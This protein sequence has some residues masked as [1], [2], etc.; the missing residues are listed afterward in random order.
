MTVKKSP[1]KSRSVHKNKNRGPGRKKKSVQRA[2]PAKTSS[3]RT[4]EK[5]PVLKSTSKASPSVMDPLQKYLEEVSRYPLLSVEEEQE[6]SRRYR[7]EKDKGA[8]QKLALSNLR[9]VV[10]IANEYKNAF[11]NLLDLVQEGNLGLLR[12][13]EKFDPDRGVRFVSYAAWWVRAFILKYILDNFR[14]VKIGTTQAQKKLFFNLMREKDRI[15]K[16]GFAASAKLLSHTLDVK[17]K[18]VREMQVR[19]GSRELELDAPKGSDEGSA[20]HLDF[21]ASTDDTPAEAAERQELKD[22]LMANLDSFTQSL[23]DKERKIFSDRL[24]AE[25]PATLQD[26]AEHYQI[27]RERIRQIEERV[28]KKMREFFTAKGLKVDVQN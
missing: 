5:L 24:F 22:I 15:E 23:S 26:I 4:D 19:L 10:K 28:I 16:M 7:D 11:F 9:L 18:D 20:H 3:L 6:L 27:S 21:V 1:A 2:Q 17:E 13:V 12:A 14:L 25:V 8:A